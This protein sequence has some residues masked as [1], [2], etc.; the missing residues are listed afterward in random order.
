M[1]QDEI[2]LLNDTVLIFEACLWIKRVAIAY[3]NVIKVPNI[4]KINV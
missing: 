3:K 4:L 2:S 1:I